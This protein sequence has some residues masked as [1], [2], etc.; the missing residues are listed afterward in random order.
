[1]IKPNPE[2]MIMS[3]ELDYL[4][5]SP[6]PDDAELGV[7]GTLALL[8]SENARVGVLDLT[9]GEPT[10]H[11]DPVT[12]QRETAEASEVLQLDFRKNLGLRNRE[13]VSDLHARRALAEEIRSL[14]PKTLFVPHWEDIHP[15]HV[16][17][18]EIALGARFWGKLSKTDL[19]GEPHFPKRVIYY[20]GIHLRIHPKPS[21]VVDITPH[22]DTKMRSISCYRSQFITG[23]SESFPTILDDVR[24]RNRYWG[25]SI[26]TSYGEPMLMREE[27]GLRS[28]GNLA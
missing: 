6:H 19:Q 7:G 10:P 16:A 23:R 20:F 17:A 18:Y 5:I 14:K 21:F 3:L 22:I 4:V 25:W 15:D 8:K 24:D 26:G 27:V 28:L 13:L 11:G 9:S 1:M 2:I 12:R